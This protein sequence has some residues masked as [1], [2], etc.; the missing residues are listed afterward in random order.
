MYNVSCMHVRSRT[1]QPLMCES[2][3][4]FSMRVQVQ[5]LY[6][7][8]QRSSTQTCVFKY[9]HVRVQVPCAFKLLVSDYTRAQSACIGARDLDLGFRHKLLTQVIDLIEGRHQQ[10]RKLQRLVLQFSSVNCY[11]AIMTM[12]SRPQTDKA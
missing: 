4:F 1:M 6:I 12:Q 10:T 7:L 8:C 2:R 11:S 9:L 3:S 5:C